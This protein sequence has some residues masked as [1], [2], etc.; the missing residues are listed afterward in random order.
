MRVLQLRHVAAPKHHFPVGK[1]PKGEGG[2]Y[3]LG[4]PPR[5][6]PARLGE[7]EVQAGHRP[8]LRAGE[9]QVQ[10]RGG[11][12]RAQSPLSSPLLPSPFSLPYHFPP[13][14]PPL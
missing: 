1:G 14:L 10:G 2:T 6:A 5:P 9:I 3:T 8:R 11:T 4:T 7:G 12:R 13:P